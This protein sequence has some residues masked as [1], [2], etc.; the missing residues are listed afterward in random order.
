MV[1]LDIAKQ[2]SESL[3]KPSKELKETRPRPVG[4]G[5]Q[6]LSHFYQVL[7][8]TTLTGNDS[9]ASLGFIGFVELGGGGFAGSLDNAVFV[10]SSTVSFFLS[11]WFFGLIFRQSISAFSGDFNCTVHLQPLADLIFHVLSNLPSWDQLSFPLKT[12]R[13]TFCP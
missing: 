8:S 7:V 13:N 10:E 3:E 12:S 4:I 11:P 5:D 6:A 2:D 9:L 1:M